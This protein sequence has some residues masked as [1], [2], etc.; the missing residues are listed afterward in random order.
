MNLKLEY[1]KNKNKKR[2]KIF[3]YSFVAAYERDMCRFL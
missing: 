3:E 1:F 2:F